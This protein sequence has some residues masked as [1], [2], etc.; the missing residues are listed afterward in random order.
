[1]DL[2]EELRENLIQRLCDKETAIRAQC[3]IALAR[4]SATEDPS[5]LEE[6][7]KSILELLTES[8]LYDAEKCVAFF[9]F[10]KIY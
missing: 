2:Y 5:E 4:L 10:R 7:A 3:V 8:L 6:G 1:M 9:P